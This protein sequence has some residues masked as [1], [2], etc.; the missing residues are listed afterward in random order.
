MDGMEVQATQAL[1]MIRVVVNDRQVL[2]ANMRLAL[3]GVEGM[4]GP[5]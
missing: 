1:V 2:E 5:W 4:D 3:V